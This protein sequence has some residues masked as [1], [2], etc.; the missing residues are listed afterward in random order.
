MREGVQ[1]MIWDYEFKREKSLMIREEVRQQYD[2]FSQKLHLIETRLK[3]EKE[4]EKSE[5][6]K[7]ELARIEDQKVI[8]E[9]E[10]EKCKGQM[11]KIDI[12]VNG[13]PPC[14]QEPEGLVGHNET[15]ESLR[16][17]LGMVKTYIRRI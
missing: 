11:S 16:E 10:I 14:A 6:S 12:D 7:D 9:K 2:N 8:L 5:I 1:K 13:L 4:K 17:L 3:A 15:I